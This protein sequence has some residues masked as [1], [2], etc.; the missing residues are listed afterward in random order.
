MNGQENLSVARDLVQRY[1]SVL[2]EVECGC[3]GGREFRL[4]HT[5][6]QRIGN[7]LYAG[8]PWFPRAIR[9]SFPLVYQECVDCGAGRINPTPTRK[10]VDYRPSAF[11]LGR[12]RRLAARLMNAASW[13]VDPNYVEEKRRSLSVHYRDMELD[14]FRAARS[15]VLDVSCASGVGLE[16]LRDD[17]KWEDCVGVEFDPEAVRA[18]RRRG[19]DVREGTIYDADL[20][21]AAFGLI[22]LDNALEHHWS[23]TEALRKAAA[24][25]HPAGAIFVVV[26]NFHGYAVE[27]F[28]T[29]YG[30]L[31]WGHWHYFTVQSLS[32]LAQRCGLVV[33][34]GYSSMCE[35]I[36]VEKLGARPDAIDVD[37]SGEEIRALTVHEK[38]FR[39]EFIHLLFRL[40]PETAPV[41]A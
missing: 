37:M 38:V 23:P 27:L 36:V 34:R 20:P 7:S 26:P 9:G 16:L 19:M 24:A 31:N 22:I 32:R 10:W 1:P 41:G 2:A 30:N 18:A 6:S 8:A 29:D 33:E 25:L 40:S 13:T 3:C 12:L 17:L 5:G 11:G 39:G 35:D 15:A 21:S 28:G 4:A 14:R